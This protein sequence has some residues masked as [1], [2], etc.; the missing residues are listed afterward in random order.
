[1]NNNLLKA[2]WLG[3]GTLFDLSRCRLRVLAVSKR[4]QT[5]RSPDPF[6]LLLSRPAPDNGT[7]SPVAGH[8]N[9]AFEPS[10][11]FAP[12]IATNGAPSCERRNG[13]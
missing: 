8:V 2:S 10:C 7:T 1:M 12:R 4:R 11:G 9:A 13:C 3:F 5:S 6:E